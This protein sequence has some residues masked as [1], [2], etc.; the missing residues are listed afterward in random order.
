MKKKPFSDDWGWGLLV[1]A[2]TGAAC[3]MLIDDVGSQSRWYVAVGLAVGA[4]VVTALRNW[5]Y[6]PPKDTES[7]QS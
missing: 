3:A 5:F 1:G 4:S 2:F 7:T 6:T